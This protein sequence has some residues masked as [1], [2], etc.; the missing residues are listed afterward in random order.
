MFR[1]RKS[2]AV[3]VILLVPLLSGCGTLMALAFGLGTVG[4]MSGQSGEQGTVHADLEQSWDA[5]LRTLEEMKCEITFR[6]KSENQAKIE[7]MTP[8]NQPAIVTLRGSPEGKTLLD[9]Q[10]GTWED[11]LQDRRF[12]KSIKQKLNPRRVMTP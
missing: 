1:V 5:S 3:L 2:A 8:D 10:V 11:E 9:V 4:A 12:Y 6:K 7:A